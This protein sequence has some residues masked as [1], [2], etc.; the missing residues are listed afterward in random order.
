[1]E[2]A[3]V[4]KKIR[5]RRRTAV[6]RSRDEHRVGNEMEIDEAIACAGR[7]SVFGRSLSSGVELFGVTPESRHHHVNAMRGLRRMRGCIHDV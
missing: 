6:S 2:R 7:W 5:R 3:R 4:F 1:V